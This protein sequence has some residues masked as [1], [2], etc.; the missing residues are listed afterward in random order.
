[1]QISSAVAQIIEKERK[2]GF[3]RHFILKN[4]LQSIDLTTLEGVDDDEKI[5]QICSK[6]VSLLN[7]DLCVRTAAVCVYPVF[8]PVAKKMLGGTG[9]KVATVTGG[10]PSGQMPLH[11]R[12][13]ETEWAVQK[14]ADEIDMVISRGKMRSGDYDFIMQEISEHKNACGNIKLKVILETG[15]LSNAE[16]IQ[17]AAEIAIS[18]GADF[19]KTST[20]KIQ[21]A[22]TLEASWVILHV[23]KACY[24]RTG[25]KIGF[26]PSGGIITPDEA[27]D[28]YL[29]VKHILG[30][31]WMN[32]EL[33]RYGASRLFDNILKS[34]TEI[35]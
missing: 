3:D 35:D 22:A 11:L 28:Y 15:E 7:T 19:I 31:E 18:S 2:V 24:E 34:L 1:M 8:V 21:P 27:I 4:I 25:K 13:A 32:N 17:K 5:K 6:S 23:I 16:M 10:F 33:L 26:K 20:G 14:G 30:N 9:V 12:I 29:L